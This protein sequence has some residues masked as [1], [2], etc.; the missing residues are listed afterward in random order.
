MS[1]ISDLDAVE[2]LEDLYSRADSERERKHSGSRPA[3][4]E[5]FL[6]FRPTVHHCWIEFRP[7]Y[8]MQSTEEA[9]FMDSPHVHSSKGL[10]MACY[11]QLF[12]ALDV[13]CLVY[14]VCNHLIA[15]GGVQWI[16]LEGDIRDSASN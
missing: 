9:P 10:C 13:E 5:Y 16:K 4:K 3:L 2:W 7:D 14:T 8:Q 6:Y 11:D 15:D 1:L 12:D